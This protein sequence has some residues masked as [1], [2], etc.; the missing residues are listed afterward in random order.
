MTTRTE[1]DT[2]GGAAGALRPLLG[3]PDPAFPA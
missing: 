2:M 1:T 3:L